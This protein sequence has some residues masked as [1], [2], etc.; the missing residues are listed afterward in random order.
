MLY[1][2]IHI[3][4]TVSIGRITGSDMLQWLKKNNRLNFSNKET[5][6]PSPIFQQHINRSDILWL[7]LSVILDSIV[8]AAVGSNNFANN[9]D[10]KQYSCKLHQID[11]LRDMQ[12]SGSPTWCYNLSSGLQCTPK[13]LCMHENNRRKHPD[14]LVDSCKH[15]GIKWMM[16][17]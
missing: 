10:I 8:C 16:P 6:S 14:C 1:I 13:L 5:I 12:N 2:G 9:C 15:S 17:G 7:I 3:T 11:W 4:I